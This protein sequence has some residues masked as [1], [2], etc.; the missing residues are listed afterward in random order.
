M[1][2]KKGFMHAILSDNKQ[3]ESLWSGLFTILCNFLCSKLDFT[4]LPALSL[5]IFRG[6]PRLAKKKKN[7]FDVAINTLDVKLLF[8]NSLSCLSYPTNKIQV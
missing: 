8:P 5:N 1:S 2:Y 6:F 4:K 3:L 7:L